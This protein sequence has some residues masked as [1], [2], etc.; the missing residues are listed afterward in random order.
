MSLPFVD[1]EPLIVRLDSTRAETR[2]PTARSGTCVFCGCT[3]FRA[4]GVGC[5]WIDPAETVCSA[6]S[7]LRGVSR[8]EAVRLLHGLGLLSSSDG[9]RVRSEM[10]GAIE[11]LT[12]IVEAIAMDKQWPA[13]IKCAYASAAAARKGIER[14]GY[15]VT[16]N[17]SKGT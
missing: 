2:I 11:S 10:E 1:T 3:D 6:C 5:S 4:C 12:L 15:Y 16:L 13:F 7:I 9:R 8:G 17:S 14:L